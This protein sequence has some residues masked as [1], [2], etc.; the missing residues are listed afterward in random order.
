[1]L[2]A[3]ALASLCLAWPATTQAQSETECAV[4]EEGEL[5]CRIDALGLYDNALRE[6]L[7]N[8]F[9]N[10]LVYRLVLLP[11]ERDEPVSGTLVAFVEVFRLYTDVYYVS[12]EGTEG[13]VAH[14]DWQSALQQL[15]RFEVDF[16]PVERI[17]PGPFDVEAVLEINPLDEAALAQAR[18]WIARTRRGYHLPGMDDS[19]FGSYVSLFINVEPGASEATRRLRHGPIEIAEGNP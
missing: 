16:G 18:S 1:M 15:A 9:T 4:D 2:S 8:G 12:R 5:R 14:Y 7:E 3:V 6:I 11:T 17:G 13:Y 19:L 10:H